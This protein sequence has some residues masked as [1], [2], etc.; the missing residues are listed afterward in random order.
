MDL[1]LQRTLTLVNIVRTPH[2]KKHKIFHHS[3]NKLLIF[4]DFTNRFKVRNTGY[5]LT[6]E[7]TGVHK[8][9]QPKV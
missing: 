7:L 9:L 6:F 4:E 2:L 3:L 8:T 1:L 5:V